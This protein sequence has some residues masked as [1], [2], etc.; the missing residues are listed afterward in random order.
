MSIL[1]KISVVVLVFLVV[2]SSVAFLTLATTVPNYRDRFERESQRNEL[3]S[4][5][6]RLKS[7]T[8]RRVTDERDRLGEAL[9]NLQRTSSSQERALARQLAAEKEANAGMQARLGS[10][11]GH[12]MTIE[13]GLTAQR[14]RNEALAKSL[15]GERNEKHELASRIRGL[16]D[17]LSK[18]KI[19]RERSDRELEY[20]N[21]LLEDAEERNR[22]LVEQL[23]TGA[24]GVAA[25]SASAD[26]SRSIDI[27][28][29][30]GTVTGVR[31]ELAS[32]NIG[33][34]KGVTNGME[35]MIF[36]GGDF[37]AYLQVQDVQAS[38]AAG[39]VVKKRL[40]PIVGDKV[41]TAKVER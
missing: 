27:P 1:T 8:L 22:A 32:I 2:V 29:V 16:S 28:A 31:G 37:V 15:E 19:E 38:S 7:L 3:L 39:I 41:E 20:V 24:G 4:Q 9:A 13:K 5:N 34:A 17:E 6:D 40:D 14:Q 21:R 10:V 30:S 18:L 26:V 36:R 33:S 35:L 25:T 23:R 12:L 11:E